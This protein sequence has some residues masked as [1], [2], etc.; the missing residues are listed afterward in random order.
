MHVPSDWEK[1][2]REACPKKPFDVKPMESSDFF[3]PGSTTHSQKNR[4]CTKAGTDQQGCVDEFWSGRRTIRKS[5][6]TS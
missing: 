1:V 6:E 3:F 4:C 5:G 2:V